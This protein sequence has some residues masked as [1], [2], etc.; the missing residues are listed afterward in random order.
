MHDISSW[1]G[2]RAAI[3]W[4]SFDYLLAV[5][6]DKSADTI[7]RQL[8]TSRDDLRKLRDESVRAAQIPSGFLRRKGKSRLFKDAHKDRSHWFQSLWTLQEACLRPDM[9]L[10]KS[11]FGLFVTSTD[12]S[13]TIDMIRAIALPFFHSTLIVDDENR[14][15]TRSMEA[16]FSF[17]RPEGALDLWLLFASIRIWSSHSFFTSPSSIL[18]EGVHRYCTGR[19]VEAIMSAI[20]VTD[21]FE[22]EDASDSTDD[23]QGLVL[24]VYPLAFVREAQRK[25]G[26]R[27]FLS[28]TIAIRIHGRMILEGTM[29]PFGRSLNTARNRPSHESQTAR[30]SESVT[31]HIE[32]NSSDLDSSNDLPSVANWRV[33]LD[34]SVS[35]LVA[36]IQVSTTTT[37]PRP[38]PSREIAVAFLEKMNALIKAGDPRIRMS[39]YLISVPKQLDCAG[40]YDLA[41]FLYQIP[42]AGVKHAICVND[43]FDGEYHHRAG[44]ILLSH[45]SIGADHYVKVGTYKG[46]N[47]VSEEGVPEPAPVQQVDWKFL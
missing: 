2:L 32:D 6:I 38:L 31:F 5:T 1:Q 33:C 44:V 19:R 11:N 29:I 36:A 12:Y 30:E 47:R 18:E 17:E 27:F 24:G 35:I 34:G 10:C 16:A 23:E 13:V 43:A 9:L 37:E 46:F 15:T 25:L 4:L 20:G 8:G 21:W 26:A 41:P 39:H 14:I 45:T 42:F 28:S 22:A 40:V 3:K 7:A